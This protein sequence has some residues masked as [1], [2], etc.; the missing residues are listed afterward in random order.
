[1]CE[2]IRFR[3]DLIQH[4]SSKFIILN[5]LAVITHTGSCRLTIFHR[6]PLSFSSLYQHWPFP[7]VHW[8][9]LL[10]ECGIHWPTDKDKVALF[11]W[12]LH[13]HLNNDLCNELHFSLQNILESLL[14]TISHKMFNNAVYMNTD[15][16]CCTTVL[17]SVVQQSNSTG[18]ILICIAL[19]VCV[20]VFET[21]CQSVY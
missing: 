15:Y 18:T 3:I 4:L 5:S 2:V 14:H 16:Y 6:F 10:S 21:D 11:I 13:L 8:V 17:K 20:H 1:M 12:N 19:V 7:Q 9:S